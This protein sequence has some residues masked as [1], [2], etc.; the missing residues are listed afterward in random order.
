MHQKIQTT[1]IC[2]L[3]SGSCFY[4]NPRLIIPMSLKIFNMAPRIRKD[5]QERLAF[6]FVI[7]QPTE[8]MAC[9]FPL[10]RFT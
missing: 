8:Q 6:F 1:G 3:I 4:S 10:D 5:F 9:C 7:V 2:P